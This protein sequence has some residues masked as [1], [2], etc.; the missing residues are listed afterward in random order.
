M[1]TMAPIEPPL[2]PRQAAEALNVSKRTLT[3][4]AGL[5]WVTYQGGGKKPIKRVTAESVRRLLERKEDR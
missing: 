4:L 2:T 5:V 3:R 1:T